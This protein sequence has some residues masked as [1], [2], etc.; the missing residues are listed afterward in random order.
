MRNPWFDI[1]LFDYEGHMA[2]PEIGQAKLLGD[3]FD[4]SLRR[5]LPKSVAVIGCAGGNGFER[6]DPGITSRVVGVDFN[7]DYLRQTGQRFDGSFR[8][9]ELIQAN[10]EFDRLA[11]L[12]VG[13]MYAALVLEYVDVAKALPHLRAA[14]A[15]EGILI[16]VVQLPSPA[17]PAVSASPYPSLQ[18]LEPILNWVEPATLRA[19]A[20]RNGLS[21]IASRTHVSAG[22]KHFQEQ[23]FRAQTH[24]SNR[25]G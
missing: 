22:G 11:C 19:Q 16:T 25:S 21:E 4:E 23:N 10:I 18:A 1:P 14:L 17:L 12:P 9:L 2:L 5:Y 6:I 15:E 13:L 24:G 8:T 20:D 7:T 3:V